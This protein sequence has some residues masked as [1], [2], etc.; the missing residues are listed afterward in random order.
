VRQLVAVPITSTFRAI[1]EA[2]LA[3]QPRQRFD[4]RASI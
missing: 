1:A 2:M 3:R 4:N